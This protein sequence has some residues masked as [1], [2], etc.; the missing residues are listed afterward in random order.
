MHNLDPTKVGVE[1]DIPAKILIGTNE[2]SSDYLSDTYNDSKTENCYPFLLKC[3]S[4]RPIEKKGTKAI[5]Y[6]PV[7][8]IPLVSKRFER[9]MY[10]E[11]ISYV[12]RYLST[13]LFGFRRGHSTEHCL[14]VMV[15][16]WK[17]A[18]DNKKM[19]GGILT[20]LSKAFDCINHELLMAKLEA[21][22]FDEG[23]L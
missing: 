8:L 10:E 5:T 19:T 17:K 20:D 2:I 6:R 14:L 18:L 21:Y 15:E 13:Y 9:H 11:M 23:A 7:S 1:S 12:E 4:I 22:G 3:A 16:M